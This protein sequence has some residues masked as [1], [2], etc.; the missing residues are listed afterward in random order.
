MD[1]CTFNDAVR[2]DGLYRGVGFRLLE[3]A[4][5][6]CVVLHVYEKIN[7]F[8]ES[9]LAYP[10]FMGLVPR[11]SS[12]VPLQIKL[13]EELLSADITGEP[14][15]ANMSQIVL[16]QPVR[17]HE[18]Y[19]ALVALVGLLVAV[20]AAV[21]PEV[22]HTREG[23]AAD[24]ARMRSQSRVREQVLLEAA[25]RWKAGVALVARVGIVARVTAVV[26][27]EVALLPEPLSADITRVKG[28]VVI[29]IYDIEVLVLKGLLV[30]VLPV[31][32]FVKPVGYCH[33]ILLLDTVN[34]ENVFDIL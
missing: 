24:L 2:G 30:K 21:S 13:L 27:L 3:L 29:R 14:L 17:L 20:R 1:L 25:H 31:R 12:T 23:L 22:G 10:A 9:P 34:A 19:R 18:P 5:V 16:A 11:V 4:S 33:R 15:L 8:T 7:P 6:L 28:G 32:T 26:P